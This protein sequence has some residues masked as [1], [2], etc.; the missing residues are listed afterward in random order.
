MRLW[1]AETPT[2]DV[3]RAK[4]GRSL[5]KLRTEVNALLSMLA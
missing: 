3:Y 1:E 5:R 2:D 4:V